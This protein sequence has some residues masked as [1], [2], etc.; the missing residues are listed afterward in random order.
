MHLPYTP[1]IQHTTAQ[2]NFQ[3][4]EGSVLRRTAQCSI[5]GEVSR[6]LTSLGLME[7]GALRKMMV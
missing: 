4:A 6:R 7:L 2:L 5:Q 1:N 3:G